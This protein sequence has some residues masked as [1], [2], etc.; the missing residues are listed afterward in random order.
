MGAGHLSRYCR[1]CRPGQAPLPYGRLR[2]RRA[3]GPGWGV[4]GLASDLGPGPGRARPQWLPSALREGERRLSG[5]SPP[6]GGTV[7]PAPFSVCR[8]GGFY[9]SFPLLYF[10][11][12]FFFFLHHGGW[13]GGWSRYLFLGEGSRLQPGPPESHWVLR[14]LVPETM[15]TGTSQWGACAPPGRSTNTAG[16]FGQLWLG[17]SGL[18]SQGRSGAT[19]GVREFSRVLC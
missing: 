15:V 4:H 8:F 10:V 19:G 11:G 5:R 13:T 1:P 3:P 9:T 6:S 14:C 18:G 7:P 16:A 17:V 2:S 12:F